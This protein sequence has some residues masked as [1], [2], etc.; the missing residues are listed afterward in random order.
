MD[1][2]PSLK[3]EGGSK[4][5]SYH[6]WIDC[7]TAH[8]ERTQGCNYLLFQHTQRCFFPIILQAVW[9]NYA[10]ARPNTSC[11][12]ASPLRQLRDVHSGIHGP[13]SG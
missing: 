11:S 7:R 13:E 10:W 5:V 3:L 9:S 2:R 6:L 4:Y 8:V 1:G 12:G